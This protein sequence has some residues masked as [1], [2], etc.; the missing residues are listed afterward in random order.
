[1][2]AD[3][4]IYYTGIGSRETPDMI[5][6]CM[7]NEAYNFAMEGYVLRSGG[8]NGADTA[9]EEGCDSMLGGKE[10][11]IPWPEFNDRP[12]SETDLYPKKW[13]QWSELFEI[14]EK[15]HPAWNNLSIGGKKL[16]ARNVCQVLGFDL[17]TPSDFV[18]CWT[19]NGKACGGTGQAIRIAEHYGI[20]VIN[21]YN[22]IGR[23]R[24]IK[25]LL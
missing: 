8:A 18:M 20:K 10:I 21:L 24:V 6:N 22:E 7:A 5:L 25:P 11:Y 1:M 14:A 19:K 2:D 4:V 17:K 12:H 23:K 9:F 3:G 16:H 13:S 15:F